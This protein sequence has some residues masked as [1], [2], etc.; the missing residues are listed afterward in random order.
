MAELKRIDDGE[1]MI[2]QI[3]DITLEDGKLTG[4][5]A[6]SITSALRSVIAKLNGLLTFGSGDTGRRAGNI[7]AVV[8]DYLTPSV[9]DT[10][11][12]VP[13]GLNRRPWGYLVVRRDKAVTVYDSSVGSWDDKLMYLKANAS[14]ATVKLLIW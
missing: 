10:E 5:M 8:F 4:T 11:F 7:D 1:G 12:P 14:S 13:H 6:S 9:A 2:G 3:P